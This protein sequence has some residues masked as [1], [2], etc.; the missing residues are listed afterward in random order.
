MKLR[1]RGNSIRLRLEQHEIKALVA[2]GQVTEQLQ[3][4]ALGLFE[5]SLVLAEEDKFEAGFKGNRLS[6]KIPANQ[7]R[8]WG[9]TEEVGLYETLHEGTSLELRI[10]VEKDF[11]CLHKR[12][13]E[14]ESDL[15]PNPKAT[16]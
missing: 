8:H 14:D 10:A 11:Q 12:P 15:F 7:A 13:E 3:M 16:S 6:I 1:L 4:G 2:S 9:E 5:Y